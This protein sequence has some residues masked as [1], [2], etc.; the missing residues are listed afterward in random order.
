[1]GP[2]RT[3]SVSAN[4]KKSQQSEQSSQAQTQ[5]IIVTDNYSFCRK[6]YECPEC[7]ENCGPCLCLKGILHFFKQ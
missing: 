7:G 3:W 2:R 1:M 4:K 6:S 5:L